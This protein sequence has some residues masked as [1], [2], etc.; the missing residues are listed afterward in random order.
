MDMRNRFSA[1]GEHEV[2]VV[3]G[4][5]IHLGFYG[6]DD[7]HRLY[8]GLGLALYDPTYRIRVRL[9]SYVAARG[10]QSKRVEEMA[11]T[12]VELLGLEGLEVTSLTCIPEHVGLGS[13]TQLALA[14]YVG[15]SMLKGVKPKVLEAAST[16]GRGRVS[17]IGVTAFMHGGFI[18]DAGLPIAV[19]SSYVVKPLTRLRFPREWVPVIA[20]PESRWRVSEADEAEL[21]RRAGGLSKEE[22]MRLLYLV[23]RV[24]IPSVIDRDFYS[25][26]WALEQVQLLTGKYFAG[27]QQ[28]IFCCQE[29][30]VLAEILRSLGGR[31]IG[32]SSWGPLVYAFF[33]SYAKA[34]K[35]TVAVRDLARELGIRLKLVQPARPRNRGALVKIHHST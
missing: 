1:E 7:R 9:S 27:A 35:A 31:G 17:G 30:M 16:L 11:K 22:R 23:F 29:S 12:V 32:Q 14:L 10:C 28:G 8:G 18:V 3:T 33:D 25:F 15:A 13:T 34:Q 24:L 4:S 2:L 21:F 20:V 26:T 5:R 19:K 6:F